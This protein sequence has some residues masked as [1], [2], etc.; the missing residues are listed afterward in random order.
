[1]KPGIYRIVDANLNRSREGLRVCEE[2]ARFALDSKP[3][4]SGLKSVRHGIFDIVKKHSG[5]LS[6]LSQSRDSD[7]DVLR[8]SR[9]ESEMKRRGLADIFAA[10]IERSKESLRVLEEIFKLVD[11]K[12]SSKLC[13]LRF[14]V[15]AIEKKA[16]SSLRA[17]KGRSNLRKV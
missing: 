3:L 5:A 9:F 7:G 14:K 16:T 6:R 1:M 17:P 8:C 15:Y 10:N 11:V 13:S 2:I 12:S 4:T